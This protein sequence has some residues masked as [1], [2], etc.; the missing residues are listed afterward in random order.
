MGYDNDN[1]GAQKSHSTLCFETFLG[2]KSSSHLAF[3]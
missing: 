2:L 3:P 1:L